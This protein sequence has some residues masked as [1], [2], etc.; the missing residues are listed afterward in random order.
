MLLSLP[1]AL[2]PPSPTL[3]LLPRPVL[4][5]ADCPA[6]ATV[7]ALAELP[8]LLPETPGVPPLPEKKSTD[9]LAPQPN[10]QAE[11][12]PNAKTVANQP[13]PLVVLRRAPLAQVELVQKPV[14]FVSGTNFSCAVNALLRVRTRA[15]LGACSTRSLSAEQA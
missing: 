6:L 9:L 4:P 5:A 8:V 12:M 13:I 11:L 15:V 2:L 14:Q 10:T 3:L 1:P 7:P